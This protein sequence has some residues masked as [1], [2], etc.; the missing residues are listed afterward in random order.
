MRIKKILIKPKN[1]QFYII[2]AVII[3]FAII[4]IATISTYTVMRSKPLSI[5]SLSSNLK[6]EGPMIIDYGTYQGKD[7]ISLL[8]NFTDQH[9]AK[10]F[11]QK[12]DKSNVIFVYGNETVMYAV[13][14]NT[15]SIG[16]VSSSIGS[17]AYSWDSAATYVE[18]MKVYVLPG[19]KDVKV[20][21]YG[22][23]YYFNLTEGKMFYFIMVQEK[24]G[25][26]YL[27]R[28]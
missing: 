19:Q 16:S 2:A 13:R 28:N 24:E 1:G 22:N 14:Y 7:I 6:K 3:V 27:S 17:G 9:Y 5:D 20:T 23:E 10:Y 11:L 15:T 21:L 12:T 25:E 8:N 26:R 18:R 4:A